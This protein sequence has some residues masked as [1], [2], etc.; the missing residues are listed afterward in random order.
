MENSLLEITSDD[1]PNSTNVFYCVAE[2]S[3]GRD[4]LSVTYYVQIPPVITSPSTSYNNTLS[5]IIGVHILIVCKAEGIPTPNVYWT[6]NFIDRMENPLLEI[7]S[8]DL[9]NSTNVFYCVAESSAGR[10][11]LSVT[12]YVQIPPVITS[13]STSY[14]N[15]LSTIIGVHILIVCKAEGIPTPNVYWTRDNI[16][17]ES[18]STLVVTGSILPHNNN[19][20]QCVAA[21]VYGTAVVSVTYLIET[22]TDEVVESLGEITQDLNNVDVISDENAGQTA[23]IVDNS[24]NLGISNPNNTVEQNDAI[25][26]SAATS[27]ELI[28]NKTNGTFSNETTNSVTDLLSTVVGGSLNQTNETDPQTVSYKVRTFI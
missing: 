14:N 22:T 4:V 6:Q 25:L 1:L 15:T 19:T 3:V 5:T 23:A 13:P 28:V 2:N 24:V 18:S 12:Y 9:P 26:Q 11:V 27:V 21:N 17:I 8:D 10:D 7:T 20:F 16:T